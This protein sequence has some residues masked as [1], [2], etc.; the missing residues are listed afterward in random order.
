LTHPIGLS[1]DGNHL[2]VCDGKDGLKVFDA[3]DVNNLLMIAQL[4]DA[5]VYDVI[6]ENGT[7]IVMAKDG[8]YEYDYSDI[9]NIHLI[10]K[11]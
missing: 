8:M 11:L 6:A 1:K 2:F 5:E 10:S 7:A 4:K 9:N 3:T